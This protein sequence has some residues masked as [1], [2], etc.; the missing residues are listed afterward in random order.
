MQLT[1][2]LSIVTHSMTTDL[3]YGVINGAA[4]YLAISRRV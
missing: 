3:T 4:G 1:A 2:N